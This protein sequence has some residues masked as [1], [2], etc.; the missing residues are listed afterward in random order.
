MNDARFGWMVMAGMVLAGLA[1][2]QAVTNLTVSGNT[3]AATEVSH[4]VTLWRWSTGS[5]RGGGYVRHKVYYTAKVVD[6]ASAADAAFVLGGPNQSVTATN[7]FLSPA[8]SATGSAASTFV[9]AGGTQ[10]L[11]LNA[12]TSTTALPTSAG[13]TVLASSQTAPSV[14][15]YVPTGAELTYSLS[16]T[17]AASAQ[18]TVTSSSVDGDPTI[19]Y[20]APN[21]IDFAGGYWYRI[22][23]A[24]AGVSGANKTGTLAVKFSFTPGPEIN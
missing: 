2:A 12:S 4:L 5:G 15:F 16:G 20:P 14:M 23:F 7:S 18:F 1:P 17:L 21:V 8:F 19:T 11:T 10:T 6:K 9:D 24:P 3:H 13:F 22:T